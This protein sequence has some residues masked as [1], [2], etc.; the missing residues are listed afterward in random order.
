M[1]NMDRVIVSCPPERAESWA[2]VFRAA[3][4]EG[5]IVSLAAH[6]LAAV[7]VRH[8]DSPDFSTLVV[9]KRPLGIA[10][11]SIKRCFDLGLAIGALV[12]LSPVML[13]AALVIKLEDGGPIFFRQKRVGRGNRLFTIYKF[14]SMS[15]HRADMEGHRSTTREDDR[16]TRA[17]RLLRAWSIDELP[18]LWNIVR[19]EMSV[20]GPR[21][22]ALGSLAGSKR[23]WEVDRRYWQRH[24]LKPGLTGL[25]QI[26]GLRGATDD[27]SDLARRLRADREYLSG[28][29]ILRDIGIVIST[30]RVIVHERAF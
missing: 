27:E 9:S 2:L 28:W 12:L 3:G 8:G 21:P 14:R 11:R 29:S 16:V 17:G 5:E 7:G 1:A 19:G 4:V 30:L 10:S 25:A 23:F 24:A 20:V 15:M 22:H 18:Q 13:T 26:R 6:R